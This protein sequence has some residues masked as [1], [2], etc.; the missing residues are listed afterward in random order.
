M[1]RVELY[2]AK[3]RKCGREATLRVY[4]NN[5]LVGASQ[6]TPDDLADFGA[7]YLLCEGWISDRDRLESVDVDEEACAVHLHTKESIPEELVLRWRTSSASLAAT[8][9]FNASRVLR[10]TDA[11]E[12]EEQLR[13]DASDIAA[14]MKCLEE[15]SPKRGSG[16]CVHCCGAG[17]RGSQ[18]LLL[19]RE[20]L[21]RHNAMDK[22]IGYAWLERMP[23]NG[24]A[25]F[26][27]GRISAEMAF[28]AL[29]AKAP[30][31]V[32][33]KSATN[34]AVDLAVREGLTVISHCRDD[35]MR[36]HS[37]SERIISD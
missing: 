23:L 12:G 4:L 25:L 2:D 31:L 28:K 15:A 16:E 18:K 24:C 29:R 9:P 22:L 20:D 17:A 11:T 35:S 5:R 3:D 34:E 32:S 10:L 33:L 19:L 36:I 7:G 21:G 27:T 13:F 30:V 1:T 26:I 37:H 8:L 6:G 14:Q